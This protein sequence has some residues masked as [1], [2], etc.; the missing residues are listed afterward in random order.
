VGFLV[1]IAIIGILAGSPLWVERAEAAWR[2]GPDQITVGDGHGGAIAY[3][4]HKQEIKVPGDLYTR[5]FGLVQMDDAKHTIAMV[6]TT[7]K[8]DGT[9]EHPVITFS[10]DAG[11]SWSDFQM[12]P[13]DGTGTA[14][15]PLMLDYLGGGKLAYYSG[16][17]RYFS[18]NYGQTWPS[19]V[20]VQSV[21]GVSMVGYEGTNGLDRDASGNA[22]RV[23]EVN[24]FWP[25]GFPDGW[26]T[27]ATNAVF[28]YSLDRGR[29]WQGEVQPPT[30]KYNATYNG[31]VYQR[32]VSEGSVV[33]A[34]NGWLV[35]AL[36]TDMPPRFIPLAYDDLEGTGVSISKDNG[37]TWSAVNGLYEAGR[38]HANLHRLP[39]GDLV[40]TLVCMEDIRSGG[41]L[42]SHKRGADALVSH[43]NGLTWNLDKR[44]T[45]DEFDYFNPKMWY[46]GGAAHLGSTVLS[47]GT[48]LT[49]Y[50][51]YPTGTIVLTKWDPTALGLPEPSCRAMVVGMGLLG[52]WRCVWG[53]RR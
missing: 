51:K 30:W 36:R 7:S 8:T 12:L 53:R 17:R 42:D 33:R 11:N 16:T 43:D 23:M 19:S 44:I 31:Q 37:A 9:G 38:H 46:D 2:Q 35:A 50:G 49:A 10:T 29:T 18:T 45:L 22:T 5:P 24:H 15:R 4:A 41:G 21:K 26:P 39:N 28:R 47:D 1:A 27:A 25:N 40:M 52:A 32:G 48:M 13:T 20:A 6:A 3:P 34:A 14:T